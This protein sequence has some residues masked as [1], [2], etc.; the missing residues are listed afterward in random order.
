M[1]LEFRKI[2]RES[3]YFIISHFSFLSLFKPDSV[4]SF[5]LGVL[6]VLRGKKQNKL[7]QE[8]NTIKRK[9]IAALSLRDRL[10]IFL[11][12][13]VGLGLTLYGKPLSALSAAV[14]QRQG[15][16]HG[17]FVPFISAYLIWLKLDNI[18]GVTPQIALLPGV[19]M[20]AAGGVIFIL[21]RSREGLSLPVLS[22]LFIAGGLILVLFGT[23]VFKELSFPLFF[24][25]AMIPLPESAYGRIADWM[26]RASTCGA[27]ILVRPMGVLLFREGFDIYL[28]D[29]HLYIAHSCSGI[30]Y[31]LSYLVFGLAYAFRFKQSTTGRA[32]VVIGA[33]PLSIIGGMLRLSIIFVSAYYIGPIMVEHRPH[34]LLS[35]SVFTFLLVVVI[36][37]DQ[38]VSRKNTIHHRGTE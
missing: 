13:L 9:N 15:S 24:L 16:S 33:L 27:V 4:E 17:L 34:V 5:R 23:E 21:G 37:V 38:Y 20:A 7:K 35:W 11:A 18:K 1:N 25:A 29:T 30:R 32:L 2:H 6:R 14:L 10:L 26:A 19:A 8:S 31:L 36:A 12:V 28:P 22:F 3:V